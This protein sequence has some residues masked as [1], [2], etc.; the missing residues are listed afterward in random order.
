MGVD[1]VRKPR[2]KDTLCTNQDDISVNVL[3]SDRTEKFEY[4]RV[5]HSVKQSRINSHRHKRFLQ[6]P[7]IFGVAVDVPMYVG[8]SQCH[9]TC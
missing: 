2:I 6:I 4:L 9:A 7:F 5:T 1:D 8:Y 3:G